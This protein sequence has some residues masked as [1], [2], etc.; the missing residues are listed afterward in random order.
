MTGAAPEVIPPLLTPVDLLR[1]SVSTRKLGRKKLEKVIADSLWA[2]R[3]GQ[4]LCELLT[5]V[6]MY[7]VGSVSQYQWLVGEHPKGKE[8]LK[9][10]KALEKRGLVQVVTE[11]GRAKGSKRWPKD[12]PFTL[13]ERGQGAAR[14]ALTRYG[15]AWFCYAHGGSPEDLFRRT[16][17]GRRRTLVREKVIPHL[18]T[19]SWMVHLFY[20]PVVGPVTLSELAEV[21]G[22]WKKHRWRALVHLLM[23]ACIVHLYH[24]SGRGPVQPPSL[25][26]M[27]RF[28]KD[29]RAAVTKDLWLY[30]H[31]DLVYDI[32]GQV[33]EEG[34]SFAPGWMGWTTLADRRR[35]EPDGM[36]F[37]GTP[38]GRL[39]C[40][41]E[42][43]L[44]DKSYEAVGPRC[45]KYGS[46][47]RRDNLPVLVVCRD[48]TAEGNFH[49]AARASELRP[50]MLT[51]TLGRLKEG[52]VF[53][54]RV[55]S[56]YGIPRTLTP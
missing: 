8:T 44:S 50:R 15:R 56:E 2:G 42:V 43:E 45:D 28:W 6:G 25:D 37:L 26:W 23:L 29:L 5:M 14:Y 47:H 11:H 3:Q 22:K 20:A 40:R 16:K 52:G 27:E 49:L 48:E 10:M 4:K 36:V 51:T 24:A 32:L 53:G 35:I 39:W 30:H 34:G 21:T 54:R 12:I 41:L 9:R 31:E 18:L 46:G 55:W 1:P 19:L 7:P 17:L 13:S 33:R 38:W